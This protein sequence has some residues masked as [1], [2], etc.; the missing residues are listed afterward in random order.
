MKIFI[1]EKIY[2]RIE[3]IK[4]VEGIFR[5]VHKGFDP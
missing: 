2:K 3:P 5:A 1:V 4:T